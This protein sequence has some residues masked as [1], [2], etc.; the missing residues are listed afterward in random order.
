MAGLVP[1]GLLPIPW[2][3]LGKGSFST[4]KDRQNLDKPLTCKIIGLVLARKEKKNC[5]FPTFRASR[6]ERW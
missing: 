4:G 5:T 3:P 6:L 1:Q 2:L